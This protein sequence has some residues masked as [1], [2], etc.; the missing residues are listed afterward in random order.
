MVDYQYC[1]TG[2]FSVIWHRIRSTQRLRPQSKAAS[3]P[4]NL[5]QGIRHRDRDW[6]TKI[7]LQREPRPAARCK[8]DRGLESRCDK[9]V[10]FA[11]PLS[12]KPHNDTL[13][14]RGFVSPLMPDTASHQGSAIGIPNLSLG[15]NAAGQSRSA[16]PRKYTLHNHC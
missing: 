1:R 8:T 12:L 6:R 7:T 3:L 14:L 11:Y 10:G 4:R 16:L 15:P 9:S 2:L 13:A 5:L